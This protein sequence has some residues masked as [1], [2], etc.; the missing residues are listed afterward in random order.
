[1]ESEHLA[2]YL[3]DHLAGS[4]MALELLENLEGEHAGT[5]LEGFLAELRADITVDQQELEAL[6]EQ[7]NVAKSRPRRVAAWLTE[8]ASELKLRLDDPAHGAL[9]LLESLEVLVVGIEGKR[10][11][12]RALEF[13]AEVEPALRAADYARLAQRAEEQHDR[14]E[15]AR[16]DAA[17]A[18]LGAAS[19]SKEQG[20]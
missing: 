4:V 2:T 14:V 18:A 8:E 3:N 13:A 9:R 10:A 12:W 17:K 16:L 1:M 19:Y 6:L 20:R 15:L 11:L 7:L 5:A